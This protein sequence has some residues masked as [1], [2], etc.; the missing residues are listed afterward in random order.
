MAPVG[1]DQPRLLERL[2]H[3]RDAR[4]PAPQHDGQ[5]LVRQPEVVRADPVAAHQQPPAAPLLQPVQAVARHRLRHLGH[6]RDV[7]A[8]QQLPQRPPLAASSCR[9]ADAMR[10]AP[11][12]TCT[13]TRWGE[14]LPPK[15]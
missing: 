5:V 11:S 4:P 3:V 15:P 9:A 8:G 7:V 12:P 10:Q 6:E 2:E 13:M 14:V 1:P